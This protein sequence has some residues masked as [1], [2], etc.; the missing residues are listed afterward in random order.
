MQ[1]AGL[2]NLLEFLAQAAHTLADHSAVGFDLR[3]ARTAEKTEATALA[4][5]VSPATYEPALLIVQMRQ[6][7]L[8]APFGGRSTLPEYFENQ[9]GSIDD[10]ARKLVFEITLLDRGKGPVHHHQFGFVLFAS[11]GDVVDLP[12]PEQQIGSHLPY[13]QHEAFRDRNTDGKRK[14]FSLG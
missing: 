2:A 10:L 13:R 12:G 7:Y 5:E 14:A 6:L 9:S 11:N 3:L 4:F 1:A 8:Q